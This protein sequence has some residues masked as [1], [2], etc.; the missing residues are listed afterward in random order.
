VESLN[1]IVRAILSTGYHAGPP[2]RVS[3]L[4]TPFVGE[5]LV[6]RSFVRR[7]VWLI[8]CVGG[9]GPPTGMAAQGTQGRVVTGTV[10]REAGGLAIGFA[11]VLLK[12]TARGAQT[13]G[14]GTFRI[15]VPAEAVTLTVRAIGYLS[16]DVNI[17]ADNATVSVA[18][19]ED[20][21][22]LEQVVVTGLATGVTK[23]QAAT[24][25]WVSAEVLTRAPAATVDQSL[26]G[27]VPGANIQTNSG[28]PGGGVQVQIRGVNT[29]IGSTDPLFIVDGVIYS[30]T[31]IPS[32][33]YSVTQSGTVSGS[34]PAQDDAVNRLADLNPADIAS[35]EVMKSAAASSIYGSKAA[36]GVVLITTKRGQVGKTQANIT[37]RVGAAHLLRGPATRDFT[38]AQADSVYGADVVTPYIVNGRLPFYDHLQEIAGETPIDYETLLDLSGGSQNTRY[39]A[40][41][42]LTSTGGIMKNSDATRQTVRGNLDQHLAKGLEAN[43]TT[44]FTHSIDDRGVANNDNSGAS[45]PYSIAYIPGFVNILPANGVYPQ[46]GITYKGSNPLQTLQYVSNREEVNRFTGGGHGIYNALTTDHSTLQFVGAAGLD[47]FTDNAAVVAPAFLFFEANQAQP[48]QSTLGGGSSRQYNWNLNAV[49]TYTTEAFT[50]A[51]SVGT[52]FEDRALDLARTSTLGLGGST[53]NIDQGVTIQ[54]FQLNSHERTLALYGQEQ[55]TTL[56]E[57]LLVELG[58]R[59]ERSSANGDASKYFFY[60]KFAASYRL[61]R[62]IPGGT[63]VKLR[64]ALGAT[65]NQPLFGQK[66]TLLNCNQAIGGVIGCGVGNSAGTN[67]IAG[68]PKIKPETTREFEFGT[69]IT[70]WGGRADLEIT[71]FH[72][73]TS[74]LFLPRTPAPST[75]FSEVI[76]NGGTFQNEG[77]EIGGNI[78]LVQSRD[79][80]WTFGTSF[81]SLHNTVVSLPFPSFRP[82]T[83]GFG[84]AFGEFLV[85]PGRPI[86]QIIGQVGVDNSGNFI[87]GYMGQLNPDFKWSFTNQFTLHRFGLSML[88]DWQKGGVEQN[89]T[90]SLYD[91]NQLAADDGTPT[92]GGERVA[93]CNGPGFYGSGVGGIATPFVQSTTFLKLREVRLSY[94]L[95]LSTA[96]FFFGSQGVSLSVAGRNLILITKYFGYD[97]EV[98]NY[99]TQAI[100][101]GIDLGQYPPSRTF[102]LS[103]SARF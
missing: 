103:V 89:Q 99:G 32:G 25:V 80:S 96:R 100:T 67:N 13:D 79:F 73:R 93:A 91:C 28:A 98:S 44:A 2:D 42:G 59:G 17:A 101:R 20:P 102:F 53:R 65:G 16:K 27:K 3:F 10:T 22:K 64:A 41:G 85:Q 51:T 38:I 40:S 78:T 48:G 52:T 88:W 94:D 60:P 26:Q 75:G 8:A 45:V 86:T 9:L 72:R 55:I 34:G 43:F 21:A 5:G 36:N 77:I 18:L 29:A 83:P 81:A 23:R 30:N 82:S 6:T 62:F 90:L 74:D 15:T 87:I 50:A 7:F 57:R 69:D 24:S 97:P 46:P 47:Y 54:P 58:V 63:D 4:Q 31:A 14:S 95:P 92:T 12:G 1:S 84:L 11:T 66:F 61:P 33:L 71:Y 19:A 76:A 68:D 37:Q 35:I 56:A 39:Y 49:H 70:S